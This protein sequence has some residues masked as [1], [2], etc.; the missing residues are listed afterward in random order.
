MIKE[1]VVQK[2]IFMN[3]TTDPTTPIL[4]RAKSMIEDVDFKHVHEHKQKNKSALAVGYMPV[5]VPR[6]LLEA[7]N[8]LPVAIFGGGDQ[9]D[10]IKGDSYFQSYICHIPRS[11]I[12]LA[13]L[14]KY[15]VFDGILFPSI[16]DVIRNLSGMFKILFPNKF[17]TYVDLPQNFDMNVGGKFYVL[18]MK[19]IVR[20]LEKLGAKSLDDNVLRQKI[21]EENARNKASRALQAMRIEEPW[22]I[23][24]TESYLI[25]RAGSMMTAL[26]HKAL[27][28]EFMTA[29]KEREVRPLDNMRV[30]LA[31]SFCEQPPISLIKTLEMAGCDIVSDDFQLGLNYIESDIECRDGEKPLVSIAKAFMQK[32]CESASKYIGDKTKGQA[33]IDQV[34]N[35][36]VD[37]VIFAAASF[38]DPALLDQPMLEAALESANIPFTSLKF[39][40]NT[41]QFNVVREQAGAF[42]DSVK[43]WGAIA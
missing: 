9:V 39:A 35:Y 12:E 23:K 28:Q 29:A 41:G 38:C 33:L 3:I 8:C 43:L 34:K 37:G 26:E 31:G 15:D 18:E 30:V 11:T 27:L 25:M 42:S 21:S 24:A 22:R 6:P 4:M 7:I 13:L 16:C 10:I 32:S 17:A 20:E 19:R 5:Y 40:E 2:K 14:G 1:G 36:G